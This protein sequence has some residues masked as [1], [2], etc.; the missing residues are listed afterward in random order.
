[1]G[2]EEGADEAEDGVPTA[3][4]ENLA[5]VIY[6]SGSTGQ[7]KGVA[8][9]HRAVHNLVRGTNYITLEESDVVAQVSNSSFDA[10]TFEVWGALLSGARLVIIE[11]DVALAPHALAAQLEA[12][13]V[14]VMFLTTALFNHVA[15]ELPAAFRGLRHLLFGGE[16]V[17]P[18]WVREVLEQGRPGRLLHVYGPTETTTFAIWQ[19]V[20]SVDQQARLVPIG[21]PLK[22]VQIYVLDEHLR[23]VPVGVPGGLYVGGCGLARGYFD[24]PA[25]TGERFIPDPFSS[26]PGARLYQT[27]DLARFLPD[28]CVEFLG[29]SDQQ[30]KI[31]GFRVEPG[32]VEARLSAH[33]HVA[34]AAVVARQDRPGDRC[35]VAYF[36][37]KEGQTCGVS[38][39]RH[40]LAARLPIY[41][42]P[43]AFVQLD[44]LPL[45]ANGKVD[46]RALPPPDEGRPE[47]ETK[48]VAPRTTVERRLA[49][50]YAEVL[51]LQ[52][53][54]VEDDFFELGGHSLRAMQVISRVR[55]C[56]N[57]ELP[58]SQFFE[59][60][61]LA[62]LARHVELL[63]ARPPAVG[64]G[65]L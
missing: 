16:A 64:A 20:T 47:L 50:F 24:R 40:H 5:Y 33:P 53:V 62:D 7:P 13:G 43:S 32:E 34:H 61:T 9:P 35:L 23:P 38:E 65:N 56:F 2:E 41:M 14:T 19:E 57:V 58:L 1:V 26:E 39:L 45:N 44:A 15:R 6:T 42:V 36:V 11:K 21:R 29:R 4:A 60:G 49:G 17:E 37:A 31:R 10:A 46:R 54:G 30:V 3:G 8:I 51:G 12:H 48:F 59:T 25:L 28:G 27:G 18:K 63:A 52:A 55:D 22:N